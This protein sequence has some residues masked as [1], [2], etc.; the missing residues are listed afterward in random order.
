VGPCAVTKTTS[1]NFSITSSTT[2]GLLG[3]CTSETRR[4]LISCLWDRFLD[5][6]IYYLWLI[7]RSILG[8]AEQ[9]QYSL[10]LAIE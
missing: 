2:L 8:I 1:Y 10:R 4:L 5:V 7:L 6:G 9:F 3:L